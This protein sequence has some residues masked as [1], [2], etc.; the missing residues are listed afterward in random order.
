MYAD[1]CYHCRHRQYNVT[2]STRA[3]AVRH[4]RVYAVWF[5]R[6]HVVKVGK[7]IQASD[8][9]ILYGVL[10]TDHFRHSKPKEAKVVWTRHGGL[11]EEAFIQA[12]FQ[13]RGYL[14]WKTSAARTRL[15]EWIH[16]PDDDESSL[17]DKLD[18]VYTYIQEI[19]S[20]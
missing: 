17:V 20:K 9:L 3:V 4:S 16:C 5:P 6:L 8:Q 19:K 18:R 11:P 15:S 2:D 10:S 7:S 12:Y 13:L 1:D 14:P